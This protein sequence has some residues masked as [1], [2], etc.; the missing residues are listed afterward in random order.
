MEVFLS[1]SWQDRRF[2]D[3]LRD[4]LNS[5][6][7][8]VW[9]PDRQLLPGSNWLIETGLALERA[10]SVVFLISEDSFRSPWT[11][12][13]VEYAIGNQKFEGKVIP[14][15][16]SRNAKVPWILKQMQSVNAS[17]RKPA[18]VARE[19]ARKLTSRRRPA[20]SEKRITMTPDRSSSR[21]PIAKRTP[22][23][24]K[25]SGTVRHTSKR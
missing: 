12:R 16:L 7:L 8:K 19:V 22:R 24:S 14:V 23:S 4:R 17:G 13:E 9:D 6:G 20:A 2:A 11:T 5:A 21:L 3:A 18:D 15:L 25:R 10:D 1:Y